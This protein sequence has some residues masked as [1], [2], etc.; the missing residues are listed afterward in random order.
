[1][2][3]AEN[4][5]GSQYTIITSDEW[6]LRDSKLCAQIELPENGVLIFS[7][8]NIELIETPHINLFVLFD[9]KIVQCAVKSYQIST[10]I[11][12]CINQMKCQCV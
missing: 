11:I 5:D 2:T 12:I 1:M 4:Y 7:R 6:R 8:F 9:W 10:E 3:D